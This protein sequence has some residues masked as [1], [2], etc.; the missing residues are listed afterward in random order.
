MFLCP[1]CGNQFNN[2]KSLSRHFQQTCGQIR[3]YMKHKNRPKSP[4]QLQLPSSEILTNNQSFQE[5]DDELH[6]DTHTEIR[7]LDVGE[8]RTNSDK[9][10]I[11]LNLTDRQLI[12]LKQE[13]C[14]QQRNS[15]TNRLWSTD[16]LGKLELL[17]ILDK[18]NCHNS[19]FKDVMNWHNHY[20]SIQ[21]THNQTYKYEHMGRDQFLNKIIEK[22]DMIQMKPIVKT[23]QLHQELVEITTFDFNQ[24]LLSLLRDKDLMHPD[25]LVLDLP[26]S[27]PNFQSEFISET[28]DGEWYH[29][30]YDYYND[31]LGIDPRR[32]ICGIILTVDKTHTDWKGK[33]CLEPVQFSLSIFKKDVRKRNAN[34][35]RCLGYINDM[36][37]YNISKLYNNQMSHN[38]TSPNNTQCSQASKRQKIIPRKLNTTEQES[39]IYHKILSTILDS[40][41]TSQNIGLA[42]NFQ[43]QHEKFITMKMYF[44]LCLCVVDMKGA[45]QLCGMYDSSSN[46]MKRPC[47][48]CYCTLDDLDNSTKI[49]A[50]IMENNM[51]RV[52]LESENNLDE[53]QAMSQHK[54]KDNAFFNIDMGGWKHGIWG[55]CP[56]EI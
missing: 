27:I 16:D 52:I 38:I 13:K 18:H 10:D 9:S 35:W 36:E 14:F 43:Y 26:G 34:A 47:I 54:N 23:I 19:V 1:F 20:S 25:N 32:L 8:H 42:W 7:E 39:I 51:K 37:A 15:K 17:K 5:N 30:A 22:R 41:R 33:L 48:S 55:L 46:R 11:S 2:R 28:R 49:C 12:L 40:L 3:D 31:K 45:R 44:P 50:P 56:T 24:Q 53:L 29:C 6:I 4:V 21:N